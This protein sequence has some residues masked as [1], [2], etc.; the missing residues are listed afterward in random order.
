MSATQ[1]TNLGLNKPDRQDYVSVVSDIN[2]N[3]D[4]IDSSVGN[5]ITPVFSPSTAYSVGDYV[6]YNREL[7]R[8][9]TAHPAGSWNSSHVAKTNLAQES[10]SL[11]SALLFST[12][13]SLITGW[14]EPSRYYYDLGN[15][16]A[17]V[18]QASTTSGITDWQYV[19]IP[20]Q[21]GDVFTV[22]GNGASSP[23]AWGFTDDDYVIK[24]A[25]RSSESAND[26]VLTAQEGET[27]LILNKRP[28]ITTKESYT[29]RNIPEK[30]SEVEASL[31]AQMMN[32]TANVT[33]IPNTV[34]DYN[35]L[36][37]PGCYKVVTNSAVPV[38][39]KPMSVSHKL[40]VIATSETAKL[41]QIAIGS[42]GNNIVAI[43]R[44]NGDEW[45][46]WGTVAYK[47]DIDSFLS[48]NSDANISTITD[49]TD[50]DTLT[51]PGTYK[52]ITNASAKTMINCPVIV[53]HKMI[54]IA[55]SVNANIKQIVLAS[56]G[57]N[58][59]CIR[60][61]NGSAWTEWGTVAYVESDVPDYYADHLKA[62]EAKANKIMCDVGFYGD[63]FVIVTDTHWAKNAKNSPDLVKHIARYTPI[64]RLML[65]GDYYTTESTKEKAIKSLN[66]ALGSFKNKGLDLYI[67]PGNHDYNRG[68]NPSFPVL[69]E[70]EIYGQIMTGQNH[71]VCDDDT[72]SFWFDNTQKKIRYYFTTCKDDSSINVSSYK[73]I[74]DQMQ[75]IPSGYKVVVFT[76][77]G[78][79]GVQSY[80]HAYAE[81]LTG[82]LKA[83]REH[84][85][86]TYEGSTYNY[87]SV[88]AEPLAIIAGHSH[89]DSVF[90]YDG[91]MCIQIT[92]DS[93]QLEEGGLTREEGTI[94]EQV[95]EMV[96]TDL[97][98]KQIYLTRVGAGWDRIAHYDVVN[99]STTQTLTTV[100]NE[101]VI[102]W[103][104]SDESMATVSN[105]VVTKVG[106]GYCTIT[107]TDTVTD[108]DENET[109]VGAET[110]IIKV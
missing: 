65:L 28:S 100:L 84:T 50:Y 10:N 55:T 5:I 39:H 22:N 26:L 29:G 66:N 79:S 31:L 19:V 97:Y 61:Y 86:Y 78:L 8:F 37:T 68:T 96:T 30:I 102:A 38:G 13:A 106:S 21:A 23:R 7:Y 76:H 105:G 24:R 57:G 63:S 20:C 67:I 90:T 75:S 101:G 11:K 88:N 16:P 17:Q 34:T 47:G 85:T 6:I 53:S 60:T 54:V 71:I 1:T 95:V 107:A 62:K 35:D 82:A 51:T 58:V 49:G 32:V 9:T 33:E 15:S 18:R 59:V 64:N 25:A 2:Q 72:C 45:T 109:V 56:T 52:A 99:V 98:N 87:S 14:H 92:T 94:T 27:K 83:I 80:S 69:T 46:D 41:M 12:D 108:E 43:R 104:S 40:F 73:W 3:M 110:W 91:I 70:S 89:V 44:Y 93:Y 74:F 42:T 103:E 77:S 81:V 36:T 4:R 48:V